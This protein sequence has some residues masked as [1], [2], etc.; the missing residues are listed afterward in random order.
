MSAGRVLVVDD[1]AG[2]RAVARDLL[3]ARGYTVV[4]EADRES[5]ALEALT[6]FAPDAVMLDV[7]LGD[8]S[9]FDVARA[10][11]RVQPDLAVLLVSAEEA[12]VQ[13]AR[14]R[15]CGARG[16]VSKR[17]LVRSDLAELLGT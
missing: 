13:A 8:E 4:A 10:L 7:R 9:G 5:S 17:Q 1:H 6:R 15:G 3:R 12:D 2:F 16:F 11:M 14:V